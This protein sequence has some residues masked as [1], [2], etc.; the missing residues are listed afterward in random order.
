MKQL[1]F[2]LIALYSFGFELQYNKFVSDFNQSVKSENKTINYEGKVYVNNELIYWHYTKPIEKKI[3]LTMDKIYVY[4]PDLEQVTIYKTAKK[5]N[6]FKL[7]KSAKKIKENLYLK[8]YDN[9][10]IYF[11]TSNNLINKIYYKD[12]I[13][14]LVTLNFFNTTKK[15]LNLSFFVPKYPDY[16]DVIYSK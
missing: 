13:D 6:F 16:V 2:V 14:N 9:K 4:E 1:L 15:D 11:K 5:D 10:K 12:K 7:I 8:K 3:W